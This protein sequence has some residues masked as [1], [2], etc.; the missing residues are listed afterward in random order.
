MGH[1]GAPSGEK[2]KLSDLERLER[3]NRQKTSVKYTPKRICQNV[4]IFEK[5]S[6]IKKLQKV[7]FAF[8]HTCTRVFAILRGPNR[9]VASWA[10]RSTL[11]LPNRPGRTFSHVSDVFAWSGSPKRAFGAFG[12]FWHPPISF[13]RR[14]GPTANRPDPL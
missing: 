8:W 13:G 11:A 10:L 12:A 3:K 9:K 4:K 5:F 1:S 6:K 7:A 2:C 14:G